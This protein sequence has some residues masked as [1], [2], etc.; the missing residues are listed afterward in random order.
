M[1][2][3]SYQRVGDRVRGVEI[4]NLCSED[5]PD[6]KLSTPIDDV[7]YDLATRYPCVGTTTNITL[8]GS[9]LRFFERAVAFLVAANLVGSPAGQRWAAQIVESRIG[10]VSRKRQGPIQ[11]AKEAQ[12][13]LSQQ[14]ADALSKVACIGPGDRALFA[15]S[16]ART[17]PASAIEAAYGPDEE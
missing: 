10:P 16:G 6:G 12:A 13:W 17:E 4:L 9:S 14:G 5:L 1:A 15:T 11:T 3:I 2:T 7:V 8:T